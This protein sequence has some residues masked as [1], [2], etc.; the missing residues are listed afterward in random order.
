MRAGIH[1]GDK[2]QNDGGGG[3]PCASRDTPAES[4][5]Y[6][7]VCWLTLCKQGYTSPFF[8]DWSAIWVRTPRE[9]G[10]TIVAPQPRNTYQQTLHEQGYTG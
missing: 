2:Q 6:S 10:Y 3:A 1:P 7:D 5:A 9:Q 4:L 8:H